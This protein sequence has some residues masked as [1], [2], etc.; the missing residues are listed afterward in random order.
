MAIRQSS[1]KLAYLSFFSDMTFS[2]SVSGS[3][4]T[5][6]HSVEELVL[7]SLESW[8]SSHPAEMERNPWLLVEVVVNSGLGLSGLSVEP[9]SFSSSPS[10]SGS[11]FY[12]FVHVHKHMCKSL[13][14]NVCGLN[15]T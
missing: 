2:L 14:V 6:D 4:S 1:I 3:S 8:S 13:K 11:V 10:S 5:L 12:W 9:P 7:P 15:C